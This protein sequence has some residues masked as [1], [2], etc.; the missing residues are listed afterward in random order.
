M[1]S[2]LDLSNFEDR[3]IKKNEDMMPKNCFRCVVSGGSGSGKTMCVLNMIL[4]YLNFD[5]LHIFATSIDQPAYRMLEETF[6]KLDDM[7]EDIVRN[8]NNK[9]KRVRMEKAPPLATF[10]DSFENFSLDDL[11]PSMQHI[12]VID[13][14]ILEKQSP[15]IELFVR[16]RHKACS[17]LYL[18]QSYYQ[19]PKII[20]QNATCVLLFSPTSKRELTLLYRDLG[21]GGVEMKEFVDT[22][23]EALK[24]PYSF[25][26]FDTMAPRDKRYTRGFCEPLNFK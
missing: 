1:I 10:H 17:V 4:K 8:Y 25:V 22:V 26:K 21:V 9:H 23:E 11:D 7:R 16:G 12:I 6:G 19:T 18:T 2:N 3:R 24:E 13:D 15:M 20:R 14:M 5:Q